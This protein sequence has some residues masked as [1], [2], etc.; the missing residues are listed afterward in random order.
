M[1]SVAAASQFPPGE[2]FSTRFTLESAPR[3]GRTLPTALITVA[4]PTYFDALRV[5]MRAGRTFTPADRLDAPLVAIVNQTFV[6][7]YLKTGDPIGQRLTIGSPDRARPWITIVGVVADYR[8][9]ALTEPVRPA[10]YTPVRQ[11]T[12]WNQLFVLVRSDVAPVGLLATVRRSVTALDPEQPVYL[13]RTMED[14]LASATFQQRASALLLGIFAAVALVLAAIGTYGVMSYVVNS[15]TQE[16]GVRLA[17]GAQRRDVIWLVLAQV[18][19]L[20]AVGLAIG[21]VIVVLAGPALE[22]LLF[23]VHAADP[24]TIA[25]VALTLAAVA[26]LAAW[27]PAARASRVDPIQALRAE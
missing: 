15:R 25:L 23:G 10:I 20:V 26:L 14:A 16:M 22:G 2:T 4:T 11:Q 6:D 1:R 19:R 7:R 21:I 8:N 5:P 9:A 13:T 12:E 3:D 24:A 27:V 17:I 18:F